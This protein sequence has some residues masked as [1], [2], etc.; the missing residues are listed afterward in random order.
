MSRSALS[1]AIWTGYVVV[2]GTILLVIPNVLLSVFGV[3]ETSE[4]WIRVLGAVLVGLA[5]YYWTIAIQEI[6]P[7]MI[8]S[9]MVRGGIG[10]VLVILAFTSG[11]WQ[12]VLFAAVDMAGGLWTFLAMRSEEKP[13]IRLSTDEHSGA[14]RWR[15]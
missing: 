1:I 9:V 2:L 8:T 11:P 5:L 6:W 4:V 15:W 10:I 12:L 13:A 3:E 7:M 14:I